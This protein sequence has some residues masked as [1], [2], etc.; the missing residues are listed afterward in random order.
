MDNDRER[1]RESEGAD[2]TEGTF[3]VTNVDAEAESAVLKDVET[4]QV[5]PVS[6]VPSGDAAHSVEE[7][8]QRKSIKEGDRR[9]SI[10]EGDVLIGTLAEEPPLGVTW[11]I[12]SV[13]KHESITLERSEE[14]PTAQERSIAA[15]QGSGDLT[16]EERAG[17]G[18]LHVITVE[19]GTTDQA[20]ADILDDEATLVR[21]ARLGI[22]RVVVRT[23][24]T[25]A[26]VSVR[27]LP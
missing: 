20:A 4:G 7:G 1:P 14:A 23:D 9:K 5:H 3:L 10:M 25:E 18:E 16:V 2:T 24:D 12:D 21:A 19:P 15:N 8:D 22:E 17:I 6:S 26:I 13:E 27:Y 11:T